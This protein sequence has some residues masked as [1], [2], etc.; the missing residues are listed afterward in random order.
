MTPSNTLTVHILDKEYC[1]TCPPEERQN[2][3][4]TARYLN[5][6]LRDIRH[7]GKVIGTERIVVMT[8]L[9]MAHELLQLKK[10]PVGDKEQQ[11]QISELIN[12]ADE[13]LASLSASIDKE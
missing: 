13:T 10:Q 3:Q 4:Q 7:S 6:R 8:A 12:R 9:N 2:L 1:I 5:E 11:A